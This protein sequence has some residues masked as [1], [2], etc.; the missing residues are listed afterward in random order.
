[1][2]QYTTGQLGQ[3][4]QPRAQFIFA[5]KLSNDLGPSPH[6]AEYAAPFRSRCLRKSCRATRWKR[7][8]IT[9]RSSV[10][11]DSARH[12]HNSVSHKNTGSVR[13]GT[14]KWSGSRQ[15]Q[16]SPLRWPL[17]NGLPARQNSNYLSL[18]A[19]G[20]H[21]NAPPLVSTTLGSSLSIGKIGLSVFPKNHFQSRLRIE[22]GCLTPERNSACRRT[23][24]S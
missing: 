17:A 5:P 10:K 23:C 24:T 1:M 22:F 4:H 6:C 19:A 15:C 2:R 8:S 18:T 3:Q 7:Q 9:M 16:S 13:R 14:D 12:T 20:R 11:T 21:R